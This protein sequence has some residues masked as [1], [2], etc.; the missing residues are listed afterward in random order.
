M[1]K[2]FSILALA[3]TIVSCANFDDPETMN[4]GKGPEIAVSVSNVTDSAFTVTITPGDGATYYSYLVDGS[5][6]AETLDPYMLLKKQYVGSVSK[7]TKSDPVFTFIEDAEPNADYVVYAVASNEKGIAGEVVAV[8]VKT[9]DSGVPAL[10]DHKDGEAGAAIATFSENVKRGEGAVKAVYFAEWSGEEVEIPADDITVTISGN[11]VTLAAAN[12]PAGAYIFYSWEAGAFVD[13]KGNKCAKLESNIDWET[14]A[15]NGIYTHMETQPFDIDPETIAP[16]GDK[17]KNWEE[18]KITITFPFAIF[19]NDEELKGGEIVISYKNAEKTT[20]YNISTDAWTAED[21]VVTIALPAEPTKDDVIG[22]SISEGILYD[23]F[24]NPNNEF[25]VEEGWIYDNSAWAA[26]YVG[27]FKY[28]TWFG[29]SEE[30]QND[31][32]LI[33]YES[34]EQEGLYK[35]GNVFY[36]EDFFFTMDGEG[37]ITWDAQKIGFESTYNSDVYLYDMWAAS[38]GANSEQGYYKS[39]VFYFPT[40]YY[41]PG[42]GGAFNGF[43]TFTLTGKAGAKA[44]KAPVQKNLK[45]KATLTKNTLVKSLKK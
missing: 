24:G 5:A 7:N 20:T 10:S 22:I 14:G 41:L 21:S 27:T 42:I 43:E 37:K 28:T 15:I 2:I 33:L 8:T 11:E 9:S 31:E 3:L 23:E 26:V 36:G 39:G 6:D 32:G 16:A 38:E 25:S 13:L 17:I 30:P 45:V 19:R 44:R 12:V 34:L 4:Y 35:I 1:K 29:D 18:E 40:Y